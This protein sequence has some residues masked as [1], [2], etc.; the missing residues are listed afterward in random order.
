MEL[1]CSATEMALEWDS[2]KEEEEKLLIVDFEKLLITYLEKRGW[3]ILIVD[4]K[5]N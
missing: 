5:K 4:F 3:K 2:E 1:R